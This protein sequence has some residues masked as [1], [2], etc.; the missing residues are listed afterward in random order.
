MSGALAPMIAVVGPSG[1]G[2]DSV[3]AAMQDVDPGLGRARRVITRPAEAGGE[4]FDGVTDARFDQMVRDGAFLLHWRAHGLRYG[5]PQAVAAQRHAASGVL[6]NLSRSVLAEAQAVFGDLRVIL[7]SA[8]PEVLAARLSARGR[9]STA[10]INAR[11]A[12]A[13]VPLPAG[14]RSVTRVDNSGAVQDAARAALAACWRADAGAGQPVSA[15]L[16]VT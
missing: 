10:E 2:K 8:R 3:M 14:L 4:D 11:L 1:V 6:I 15:N 16:S 7:L 13:D 9:E 5:I 12:R